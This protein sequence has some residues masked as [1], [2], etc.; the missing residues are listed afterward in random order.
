M[1]KQISTDEYLQALGLAYMLIE[2]KNRVDETGD[3]LERLLD[4]TDDK[5]PDIWDYFYGNEDYSASQVIGQFIKDN[6]IIVSGPEH[7]HV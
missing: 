3:S 2:S 1:K 6:H 5:D 7:N 4:I